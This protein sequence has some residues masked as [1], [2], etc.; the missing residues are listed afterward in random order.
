MGLLPPTLLGDRLSTLSVCAAKGTADW[1]AVLMA[2]L[3][4]LQ[5]IVGVFI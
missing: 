2:S 3:L 5:V 1:T 4:T